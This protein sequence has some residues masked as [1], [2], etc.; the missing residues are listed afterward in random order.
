MN[1]DQKRASF[2][3]TLVFADLRQV[4]NETEEAYSFL[5][6]GIQQDRCFPLSPYESVLLAHQ[7]RALDV[8]D[9]D[10]EK[11]RKTTARSE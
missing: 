4:T 5:V 6:D 11:N 1:A 8:E 7:I 2:S 10:V 3:A 9:A